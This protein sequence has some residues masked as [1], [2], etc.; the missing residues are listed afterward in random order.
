MSNVE[1][2]TL[3]GDVRKRL[4]SNAST[5][6]FLSL[7]IGA[8]GLEIKETTGNF[9]FSAKKLVNLA[10]PTNPQDAVTKFYADA[11]S[12]GLNPKDSCVL[13][14]VEPL[15]ACTYDNV[16]DGVGA[17]LTGDAFGVL[18]LDGLEVTATTRVL[19]K[20]QVLAKHNG[21]YVV[22]SKGAA[23]GYFVLT[24]A[25][26]FD[27]APAQ[28]VDGGEYTFV[29]TGNTLA[30][31]GWVVSSPSTTAT[32]GTTPIVFVQ[33]SAAGVITAGAGMVQNTNAFDVVAADRS[34]EVAANDLYVNR[35]AAGAIGLDATTGV[36]N[37]GIKI[38]VDN[39]SIE[40]SGGNAL[41]V[42]A[43]GISAGMLGTNS[44][45]AVKLNADVAGAG[46][47]LNGT[48]NAIDINVG[49]ELKIVADAITL[50]SAKSLVNDNVGT[51]TIRQIV[52][53]KA[54]GAVDLAKA[55][56]ATLN[57][58]ELGIVE[59]ATILTTAPGKII[60]KHGA[61]VGDFTGLTIGKKLYVSRATAGAYT[62]ALTSFV[63]GEFVY[64]IG[65]AISAT[66]VS[67]CPE[68]EY[69]Y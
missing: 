64:S 28:E 40:I 26:D 10:D 42:K 4:V 48:T 15:P 20:N 5:V 19:I 11:M 22:T 44:V 43:L 23:D 12:A 33:F 47:V 39:S 34:V 69:E 59:D 67:F 56:V 45:T 68:F 61:I 36:G 30:A 58:F 49:A 62:Q 46:I 53:I 54:N 63:A 8:S 65:R 1:F 3:V 13:S 38:N 66:E 25:T 50:D 41:Q 21:I 55:N 14:S 51:I 17:T 9:D 32:I 57:D 24:R 31:T 52:Y 7:K 37:G 29:K 2:L 6:D 35:L 27:G 60:V 18:S 16:A